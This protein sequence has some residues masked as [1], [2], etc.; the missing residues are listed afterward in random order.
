MSAAVTVNMNPRILKKEANPEAGDLSRVLFLLPSEGE[1]TAED[2]AM[3][4]ALYSRDPQPIDSAIKL[5]KTAT[6]GNFMKQYY[7]GYGHESIAELGFV[8]IAIEGVPMPV[9]KLLQHYAL[10]KGQECSTRYI[11]FSNQ[12]FVYRTPEGKAYQDKLRAFYLEMLEPT[13]E[14]MLKRFNLDGNDKA[15]KKAAR[16]AAFDVLRGFLPAGATTNLAWM[17]DLRALNTRLQTLRDFV[18]EYPELGVVLDKIHELAKEAF[19]NSIHD[20][21]IA[22]TEPLEWPYGEGMEDYFCEEVTYIPLRAVNE[23]QRGLIEWSGTIDFASWRDLARHRSVFQTFPVFGTKYGFE[24]WYLTNLP[25][26]RAWKLVLE[27]QDISDNYATPMGYK[28][29]FLVSGFL[30]KFRY[31]IRL[32]SSMTVHPTLRHQIAQLAE[33]LDAKYGLKFKR[34]TEKEWQVGSKRGQQDIVRKEETK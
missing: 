6:S 17:T 9:A 4:Q 18:P 15:D 30:E 26:A 29:P 21:R 28:V 33:D 1:P 7:V 24:M 2:M 5:L 34:N 8:I 31:I 14:H 12:P 10:Y 19:P 32:R 27:A 13:T 20:S 25:E 23:Q 11:D 3:L 22:N 16:A